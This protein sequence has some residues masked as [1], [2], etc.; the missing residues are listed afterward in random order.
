MSTRVNNEINCNKAA[1]VNGCLPV[2][3][4]DQDC[5]K[6]IWTSPSSNASGSMP[7]G[8]GDISI[9]AWA[10][11]DGDLLVYIGKCDSWDENGRLLK[12]GR[13]RLHFSNSPF[14]AGKMFRQT[15]HADYGEIEIV[16]GEPGHELRVCLWVDAKRPAIRIEA[17]SENDFEL[18]ISLESWRTVER[19][20]AEDE[21][22]G[23][24]GKL[25]KDERT[26]V[27]PDII[28]DVENALAWCHRNERSVWTN[29]LKHQ[30]L[31]PLIPQF[32]DPLL[33]LTSGALV[34]GHN[35]RKITKTT[36]KSTTPEKRFVVSVHT[37]VEQTASVEKWLS[38]VLEQIEKSNQMP[39]KQ[40]QIDSRA[41]WNVFWQRSHVF[42]SGS[43]EAELVCQGYILQRFLQAC[44]S[45]GKFPI[46]FNG[47]LFTVSGTRESVKLGGNIPEVFDADFRL[48]GGG[49]WF[50]NCRLVYWPMLMSG[51]FD[52][53]LPFFRMYRDILPFA[54]Q[55]T[56][57]YF[58]HDGAF[59][60]ETMT[61]W[62]AY[63]NG[64]YGYDRTATNNTSDL[65]A[66]IR[67]KT[68]RGP[69]Q[70]GEVANSFIRRY[71]QG[72]IELL[73][74]M[75]DYH[76]ITQNEQFLNET[77]LPLSRSILLFYREHYCDRDNDGKIIFYPAQSLETWQDAVNPLPE[78]AGLHWVTNNLLSLPELSEKDK[79]MWTELRELLP[80]LPSRI[81]YWNKKKYILPAL[82]Y[83]IL[84]NLE[85]P[86]LYAVFPYRFFG[87]GKPDIDIG[88]GTYDRRLYKSTG[89]WQQDAIQSA[90]LGLT[91][92]A[93]RDLVINCGNKDP[94]SRFPGF[95]GHCWDWIPD[96][97]QGGVAMLTLQHMLMQCD[98]NRIMLFPAWPK[99]WNVSF[100]LHAPKQTTVECVYQNGKVQTLKVSPESRHKDVELMLI[101]DAEQV[102][103]IEN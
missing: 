70:T 55:R 32:H 60:P 53:M 37:F 9:N 33:S 94:Q 61:F 38:G 75:L 24:I 28:L 27:S 45:R 6:V 3:S 73:S 84:A 96:V 98:G 100:K 74:M 103:S 86:E 47:S 10:E 35:L 93:R 92:E 36:L 21:D 62:G 82:Q 17:E 59:F 8:N 44:A 14:T 68:Q 48:W 95:L 80:P 81:E 79:T 39:I 77:L 69:W 5:F 20:L 1:C 88:R 25:S 12:L 42:V 57:I 64:N 31:T 7:L 56:R 66:L 29:T 76:S 2:Q 90:L 22:H 91:E 30:D 34:N 16:A 49:Y 46:K 52:L 18:S 58:K 71:W 87:V 85:N 54:E 83:D 67:G 4:F 13:L 11:L 99:D 65:I 97:D 26:K 51:D 50:Q 102:T 63:L 78:I 101:N 19:E 23:A 89:C 41:W 72:G 40:A 43:A 15:L